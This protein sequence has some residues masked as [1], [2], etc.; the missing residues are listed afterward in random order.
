M[1]NMIEQE[2]KRIEAIIAAIKE[3]TGLELKYLKRLDFYNLHFRD[4]K[5]R[6][7]VAICYG[8]NNG[9][10]FIRSLLKRKG[11]KGRMT[12]LSNGQ[13]SVNCVSL[14]QWPEDDF[15]VTDPCPTPLPDFKSNV[16]TTNEPS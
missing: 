12:W 16:G 7:V 13:P 6:D 2:Q 5:N 4:A 1:F 15:T 3:K 14:H 9:K 11:S 10:F 8:P